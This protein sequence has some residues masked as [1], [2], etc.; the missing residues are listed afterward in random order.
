[1]ML[2][3][4][5]KKTSGFLT[6]RENVWNI[7]VLIMTKIVSSMVAKLSRE[8]SSISTFIDSQGKGRKSVTETARG[9][10]LIMP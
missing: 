5:Q 4:R 3:L 10:F 7:P 6:I 8:E 1:M 2:K 9:N